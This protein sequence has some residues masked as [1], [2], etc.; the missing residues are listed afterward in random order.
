[1][2]DKWYRHRIV[3][4]LLLPGIWSSNDP[5]VAIAKGTLLRQAK[6]E[7]MRHYLRSHRPG[8]TLRTEFVKP[9]PGN[10][11]EVFVALTLYGPPSVEDEIISELAERGEV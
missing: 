3:K 7:M 8:K 1:M 11:L 10:S 6:D 2:T 9:R 4:R 5:Q